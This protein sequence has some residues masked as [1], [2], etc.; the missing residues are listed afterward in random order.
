M[1]R[2]KGSPRKLSPRRR[3]FT[4]GTV[5]TEKEVYHETESTEK[6]LE[7]GNFLGVKCIA[8]PF[9]KQN[10]EEEIIPI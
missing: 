8:S 10:I 5:I 6:L 9:L 2:M 1:L 7:Y 3:W 4:T